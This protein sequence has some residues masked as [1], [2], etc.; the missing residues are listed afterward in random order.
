VVSWKTNTE[1]RTGSTWLDED[2]VPVSGQYAATA[3]VAG[4]SYTRTAPAGAAFLALNI[5]S[6]TIAE[7]TEIMVNLGDT[8]LTYQAYEPT[9]A[10]NPDA[11]PEGLRTL[12]DELDAA[13]ATL[14]KVRGSWVYAI[15]YRATG[16]E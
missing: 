7:P 1:R 6:N 3:G 8:A 11:L 5:K 9:L 10:L 4:T 2:S 15:Q 16:K 14:A 12:R 13:R